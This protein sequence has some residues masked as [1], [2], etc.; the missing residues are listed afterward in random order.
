M[1]QQKTSIPRGVWALGFVSL[2]M[3]ISSEMI[4]GLLPVF[5]VTVLGASALM[6]GI[7]EGIG[8][9]L[10][11]MLRLFSG[12]LSDYLKR[13]KPL[14]ITGYLLGTLSKPLFALAGNAG[15]VLT[16]RSLDRIGK[17]IRGAPRDALIADLTPPTIR[18][19]AYGLRQSL[20][21]LGAVVGPLFAILVM[22][23]SNDNFR[24][25]FWLA[26]IPGLIAVAIIIWFVKEPP[27]SHAVTKVGFKIKDVGTLSRAYWLVLAVGLVFTLARFSEAFMLLRAE[28]LGMAAHLV[29]IILIIMSF[30]YALGAYP[31]GV[32]SDKWGRA[33]LL[34]V[35]LSLLF[36]T[37]LVLAFSASLLHIAAGAALWGLHL[38]LTQGLFAALV[39][40]TCAP[41]LRGSAF[42]LFSFAT[43]LAILMASVIAGLLWDQFGSHVAFLA[44]SGLALAALAGSAI[45]LKRIKRPLGS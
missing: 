44:G 17:G 25:V 9:S 35:G 19:S 30:T 40:D 13:R 24:I 33:G 10:A 37:H 20:D 38:A 23:L 12:V 7:I 41:N 32:L 4:H 6:V 14:L 36:V 18:G 21:S 28:Q 34:L 45:L 8:E 1:N 29:P 15:L 43:G 39:A 42:G 31:A 27:A 26:A 22:W 2:F 11:L 5:L 3:D 16:A